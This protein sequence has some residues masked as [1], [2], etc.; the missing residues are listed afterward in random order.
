M[1]DFSTYASF[2]L[3]ASTAL[4]LWLFYKTSKSKKILYGIFI[5]MLIVGALGVSG[6]YQKQD[7]F[8]PRFILLLAPTTL[9]IFFLFTHKGAK[10]YMDSLSL[11]WLTILHV[12]RIPVE[13]TLYYAFLDGLIPDVMTFE[14]YN[15]DIISGITAPIIYYLVFV[16]KVINQKGLLIW[17][18]A[19]LGLLINILVIAILSAQTPFQQLAFDQPNIGVTYFPFVWLPSVIVPIVLLSHLVS[20]RHIILKKTKKD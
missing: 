20:I 13:I 19:C 15:Y 16:K 11:K 17:N 18:I 10:K 4:A 6:F 5:L 7:V 2:G 14:G 8:P 1:V 3:I 9:F 12:V